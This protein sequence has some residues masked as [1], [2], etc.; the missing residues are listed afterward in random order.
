[1]F[2]A[3][4]SMSKNWSGDWP[5]KVFKFKKGT[6][7]KEALLDFSSAVRIHVPIIT[8][9]PRQ[10]KYID[11]IKNKNKNLVVNRPW[12]IGL[13]EAIIAVEEIG[14]LNLQQNNR[15]S[16]LILDSTLEIAFKEYLL[17]ESGNG[18]S[19]SRITGFN[20]VDLQNEVK[21]ESRVKQSAWNIINYYYLRRCDL[22]HKRATTQISD[23]ELKNYREIVEY[24][25]SKM[26][27]LKFS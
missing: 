20:R 14:K 10:I 21:N 25:L 24:T 16:L 26:F 18:Y 1:M 4:A 3:Y 23:Q 12:V 6:V 22:V 17:N 13:Y 2:V 7:I 8:R 19:E 9:K 27:K 15:I 11:L 5:E